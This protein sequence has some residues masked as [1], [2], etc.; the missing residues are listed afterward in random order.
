MPN[1]NTAVTDALTA[2]GIILER[3]E[4]GIAQSVLEVLSNVQDSLIE[5]LAR[6]DPSDVADRYKQARLTKLLESTQKNIA[7]FYDEMRSASQE[8]IVRYV[9]IEAANIRKTYANAVGVDLLNVE[10]DSARLK[11]IA[12][13]TLILGAAPDAWW[14]RQ[15]GDLQH[16]FATEMQLG[17]ARGESLSELTRR[18]RGTK[19]AG[20]ADGIM[21]LTRRNITAL[22]RT[23]TQAVLNQGRLELYRENDDVVK[24]L[25][26]R[27][28]LD[29]R[30]SAI[31]ASLDGLTWTLDGEP[32]N[33][34][35]AF[36][37]PPAHWN[38]RSTLTG[39]LKPWGDLAN[40]TQ[41]AFEESLREQGFDD[42]QVS[43]AMQDARASMDGQVSRATTFGDWLKTRSTAE[44]K[45][46][47]GAGRQELF[48]A[49]KI[50]ARDLVNK[51]LRPLTLDELSAL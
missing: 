25:Q 6:L 37:S 45:T 46:V 24:G 49:G 16:K 29:L 43:S 10:I 5:D 13:E 41:A 11:E 34:D 8:Q 1:A 2:R 20:Y 27:S 19:E 9:K 14:E 7:Q 26:W 15:A 30:T 48:A 3:A 32:I 4:L 44:Q 38:C 23:S 36:Q 12:D 22:V 17:L 35:K 28:T 31:C 18:V 51:N 40:K 42:E 21:S 39:V 50:S 47:L 33:H